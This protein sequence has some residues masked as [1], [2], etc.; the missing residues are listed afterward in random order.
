MSTKKV[1]SKNNPNFRKKSVVLIYKDKKI[2]PMKFIDP[3]KKISINGCVYDTGE[4]VQ[5]KSGN[6]IK[7]A[8]LARFLSSTN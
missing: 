3:V 6:Y 1:V 2:L 5:D 4:M 7:Y 8:D